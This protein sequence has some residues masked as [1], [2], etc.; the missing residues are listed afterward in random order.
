MDNQKKYHVLIL[1][2]S[3]KGGEPF[4]NAE[5][6]TLKATL[7]IDGKPMLSHVLETISLWPQTKSITISLPQD[8][9]LITEAPT[10][11]AQIDAS[12]AQ[13]IPTSTSP[14]KSVELALQKFGEQL[15]NNEPILIVTGDAP[16]LNHS[17]LNEFTHQNHD[18]DFVVGIAKVDA[19]EHTYPEVKRTRIN[20]KGG[21]IGGCNLFIM[22]TKNAEKVV[23]FWQKL[24]NN[25]KKPWR[26]AANLWMMALYM[27]RLLTLKGAQKGLEKQ[28]GCGIGFVLVTNPDAAIDVD[29]QKDLTLVRKIFKSRRAAK[30]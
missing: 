30:H 4:V 15:K 26:L 3:R 29:K 17:I 16:L 24:E 1:A 10:L 8:A 18:K 11:K 28:I 23:K 9:P 2:G 13:L 21:A 14:C 19:V 7:D 6:K 12:E 22:N 27:L 25:R 20:L 5:G